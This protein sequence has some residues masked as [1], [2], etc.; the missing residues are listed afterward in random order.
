MTKIIIDSTCDIPEELRERF[1]IFVLPL[2]VILDK[3]AY[4]DGV[5][6][7]LDDVYEALRGGK[8]P[9]TAQISWEETEKLFASVAGAGDDF[10]YL[11]FSAAM[12]GT[13]HL[14]EMVRDELR[15]QYPDRRMEIV[16][17]KGGSMGTGLIAIQLGLMNERGVF[18]D[19]MLSECQWMTSHVKY[20]FTLSDLKCAL[21]G[22][23]LMKTFGNIV[24]ALNIRPV[25][26][27]KNGML[28]LD[29][30]VRG[31]KQSLSA[32]A[33][34]IANYAGGFDQQI[35]G[36]THADDPT[37]AATLKKLLLERLPKCTVLCQRI[38]SVLGVHLGIGG[39]GVYCL[40]SR[41]ALYRPL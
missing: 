2:S 21:R 19:E 25:L 6:I 26:D 9:G 7:Q 1:S 4:R 12:S 13:C 17:S 15:P 11:A 24:S 37:M 27:V 20:A 34:A 10:I 39:V 8:T 38:G 41:P 16:D 18:F 36:M 3:K 32:L 35:I 22:G 33:D 23:R 40:D 29:R 5:D 31:T 30:I 28:H 14:A